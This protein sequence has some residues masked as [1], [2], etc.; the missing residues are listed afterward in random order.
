MAAKASL[1]DVQDQI[2]I[3]SSELQALREQIVDDT[4]R[5]AINSQ[6]MALGKLWRKLDAERLSEPDEAIDDAVAALQEIAGDL[7]KAK[8]KL[9]NVAR[10]IHQAARAIALAEKVLKFIVV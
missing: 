6:I 1:G 2:S 5:R 7:K 10:A 8:R 4:D 9:E 3:V